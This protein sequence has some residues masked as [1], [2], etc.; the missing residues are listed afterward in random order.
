MLKIVIAG[1]SDFNDYRSFD[2]RVGEV[3]SKLLRDRAEKY[4][5]I[6]TGNHHGVDELAKKYAKEHHYFYSSY[7]KKGL[8]NVDVLDD[9]KIKTSDLIIVFKHSDSFK[10]EEILNIGKNSG[11]RTVMINC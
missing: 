8:L 4:V 9:T 11:V 3:V 6:Y 7:L 10:S 1:A 5:T 2:E